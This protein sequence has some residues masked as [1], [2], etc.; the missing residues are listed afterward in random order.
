MPKS[1]L[2]HLG[3]F[4]KFKNAY[5]QPLK[6]TASLNWQKWQKVGF[7]FYIKIEYEHCAIIKS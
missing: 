2:D 6:P 3:Y 7:V 1:N 4:R 5:N